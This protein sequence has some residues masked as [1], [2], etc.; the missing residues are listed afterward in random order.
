MMIKD[1]RIGIRDWAATSAL[2][3]D[4]GSIKQAYSRPDSFIYYDE[5]DDAPVARLN[6]ADN[7]VLS[8]LIESDKKYEY[9][10]RSIILAI[11][12]ARGLKK[13]LPGNYFDQAAINIGTSRGTT[14]AWEL[15]HSEMLEDPKGRA[16][17][18]ASPSTT[19][20]N[21]SAWVADDLGS[22]AGD[23]TLS[24]TCSS[25]FHAIANATAWLLS[26]AAEVFVAGGSEAPLTP[27]TLAQMRA[28]RIYANQQK[29]GWW[30]RAYDL[31]KKH[32]TMVLG[33]GAVLFALEKERANP[34][35]TYWIEGIGLAKERMTHGTSLTSD[36][37][38][39]QESMKRALYQHDLSDID[40]II[41]HSPGTVK[42][43]LAESVAIN[44]V[45]GDR[46]PLIT[47][48]KW[49]MGHCFGASAGLSLEMGL[50]SLMENKW[51]RHPFDKTGNEPPS[52]IKK[53]L[54]NSVGFGGNAVT[55]LVGISE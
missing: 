37:Q 45:F 19:F 54:I 50:I 34:G 36:A 3:S 31:E 40:G 10:D 27:F 11:V 18:L 28:L 5:V 6:S 46:T 4:P 47:N 44:K 41:T 1:Q 52:R 42:G 49:K 22:G 29:D 9:L 26:D 53:I 51:F 32:N 43:D 21:M 16:S 33:E 14:W 24:V 7:A 55:L 48:N 39:L 13:K 8:S 25:S 23:F 17:T 38:C 15:F 35:L 2:G 30:C 12:A 20:G